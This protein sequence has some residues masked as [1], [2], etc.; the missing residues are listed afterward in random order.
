MLSL[1]LTQPCLLIGL[2]NPGE[3]YTQNRHNIGFRAVD[4]VR[5]QYQM[6]SWS[7]KFQG[8]ISSGTIERQKIHCLLPQT[9]MNLSGQSAQ[10]AC[11]FY[12]IPTENVIVIHDDI[13]LEPGKIR[14][15]QGGGHGGHNGLKSLDSH[16][17]KNYWR[18]RVGVGHPGHR[19]L[20]SPYVLNNFSKEEE[21]SW[22]FEF[23]AHFPD[24]FPRLL[25][26]D[27]N[28]IPQLNK[29]LQDIIKG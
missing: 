7:S 5:S 13:D 2:G 18:L 8:L 12:K 21:N 26:E 15:K 23:L 11:Q 16:L 14:F 19:D 1:D 22:V 28:A 10:Q 27:V 17:G 24:T 4:T 3:K 20:V 6:P 25:L 9:F 29:R